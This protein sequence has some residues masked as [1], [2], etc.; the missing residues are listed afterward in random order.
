MMIK[1]IKIAFCLFTASVANAQTQTTRRLFELPL[2]KMN[3]RAVAPE[4]LYKGKFFYFF[5]RSLYVFSEQTPCATKISIDRPALPKGDALGF[6]F[7][8]DST[9]VLAYENT[10]DRLYFWNYQTNSVSID[11]T[12][13]SMA[14]LPTEVQLNSAVFAGNKYL[15]SISDLKRDENL[16]LEFD[17]VTRQTSIHQTSFAFDRYVNVIKSSSEYLALDGPDPTIYEVKTSTSRIIKTTFPQSFRC[18]EFINEKVVMLYNIKQPNEFALLNVENGKSLTLS[19][20]KNIFNGSYIRREEIDHMDDGP[21]DRLNKQSFRFISCRG[22]RNS[23]L[24]SF[25]SETNNRE[26]YEIEFSD[27]SLKSLQ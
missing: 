4:Q 5:D 9:I 15:V 11:T 3:C 26:L 21:P 19:L 23:I 1:I 7:I 22:G 27:K 25:A 18:L 24:L 13:S 6:Q 14:H 8:N 2:S 20:D 10:L 12:L 16:I 17:V